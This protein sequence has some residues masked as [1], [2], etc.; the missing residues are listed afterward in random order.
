MTS[1]SLAYFRVLS[2]YRQGL[3]SGVLQILSATTGRYIS[4]VL[5]IL[6]ILSAT[7][8]RYIS[9]AACKTIM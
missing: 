8:G 5:Q 4:G 2:Q 1:G 6:Q 9:R 3:I 7:T